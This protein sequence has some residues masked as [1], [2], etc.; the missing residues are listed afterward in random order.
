MRVSITDTEASK[1]FVA[2]SCLPSADTWSM[3]GL[4]PTAQVCTTFWVRVSMTEIVPA[5]RFDT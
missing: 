5:N 1:R 3:S 4:P 2:H